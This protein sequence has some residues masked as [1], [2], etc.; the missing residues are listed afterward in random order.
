MQ[1][2]RPLTDA[3]GLQLQNQKNNTTK[4]GMLRNALYKQRLTDNVLCLC[5][6]IHVLQSNPENTISIKTVT[7]R[8]NA[9]I[10]PTSDNICLWGSESY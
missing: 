10:V 6:A 8:G 4:V 2:Y 1:Q 7:Y 5:I 3:R 9:N